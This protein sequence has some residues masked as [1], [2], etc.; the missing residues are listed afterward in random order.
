MTCA[1]VIGAVTDGR[2]AAPAG[3]AIDVAPE[4][5]GAAAPAGGARGAAAVRPD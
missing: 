5:P 2:G 3:G 1:A 4:G